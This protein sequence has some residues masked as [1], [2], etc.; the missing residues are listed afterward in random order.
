MTTEEIWRDVPDYPGYVVSSHG[1]LVSLKPGKWAL[2]TAPLD[3]RGY[4][5]VNVSVNGHKTQPRVHQLVAL[6]FIGPR[7][8]GM[9][10]CHRDGDKTHN[11]AGNLRY[12]TSSSNQLDKVAHG[13]HNMAR[14]TH[15]K[16]G[17]EFTEE[18]T[19][20]DDRGNRNCRTC[21]AEYQRAYNERRKLA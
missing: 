18:N 17:H 8:D 5:R 7:P 2:K 6:A 20:I 19:R 15:C 12:G 10:V 3:R 21:T 9:E 4:P 14:K 13:T 11:W 16:R 1:R